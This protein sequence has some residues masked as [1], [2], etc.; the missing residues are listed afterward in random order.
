VSDVEWTAMVTVGRIVRPHGRRGDVVVASETDF[1]ADRFSPGETLYWLRPSGV[2]AV[3]VRS[4][5]PYDARWVVGLDGVGSI[6]EAEAVRGLELRIP[7]AALHQLEAGTFYTH[8]LVGCRVQTTG[9][10]VVGDV[11]SVMFGTGAPLLVVT[12]G[13]DETL[14]PMAEAICRSIDVAARVIV[15]DPP[16]GLLELNRKT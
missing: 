5:R 8:D 1:G 7:A 12:Q 14:V 6:D 10:E 9:G 13:G 16:E 3:R 15:V 11:S 4:G 2:E